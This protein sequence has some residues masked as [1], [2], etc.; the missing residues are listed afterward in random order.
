M[1]IKLNTGLWKDLCEQETSWKPKLG[2]QDGSQ[3][4]FPLLQE[5]KL[6]LRGVK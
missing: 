1:N 3:F 5:E 4:P 2:G 6:G